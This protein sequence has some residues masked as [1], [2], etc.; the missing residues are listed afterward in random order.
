MRWDY[1]SAPHSSVV[2]VART[3][4]A[5]YALRPI[6]TLCGRDAV[7][8]KKGRSTDDGRASTCTVCRHQLTLPVYL[9]GKVASET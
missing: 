5:P 6:Q 8:W 9:A 3:T 1:V 4:D 7:K 2:H